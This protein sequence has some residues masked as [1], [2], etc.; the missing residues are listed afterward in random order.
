M[1]HCAGMHARDTCVNACI[2]AHTQKTKTV[3]ATTG[4]LTNSNINVIHAYLYSLSI[5]YETTT[6]ENEHWFISDTVITFH[7]VRNYAIYI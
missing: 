7:L 6:T 3:S 4:S 5:F 1:T 2:H